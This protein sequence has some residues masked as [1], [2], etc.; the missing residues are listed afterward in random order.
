[1][2]NFNNVM[3]GS[4]EPKALGDFYRE[5]LGEPGWDEGG[6]IGWQVGAG[7]LMIGPH[8]EVKGRNETPGRIILNFETPDVQGEFERIKGLGVTVVREP[9]QPDGAPDMWLATF[10]DADGNYFQLASPMP[11]Q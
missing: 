3:I 11:Q 10:E 4:E 5:V 6:F 8:S 7:T 2:L 1:M 9:Y